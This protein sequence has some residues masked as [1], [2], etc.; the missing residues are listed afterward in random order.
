MNRSA[1]LLFVLV[2]LLGGCGKREE[3]VEEGAGGEKSNT[4]ILV[5][6]FT[7]K[8][9]VERGKT[10]RAIVEKVG[11]EQKRDLEEVLE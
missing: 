4:R 5:D 3:T 9:A 6:G 11:A 1:I 10:A 8:S 7:G 2:L